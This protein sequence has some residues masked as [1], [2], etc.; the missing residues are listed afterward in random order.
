MYPQVDNDPEEK[1]EKETEEED[2]NSAMGNSLIFR[3]GWSS[4]FEESMD[5]SGISN[6]EENCD[7]EK[8]D[9]ISSILWL[10]NNHRFIPD[11]KANVSLYSGQNA[12]G[13]LRLHSEAII[14]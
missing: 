13:K 8:L 10:M 6:K 9:F 1:R 3:R 7:Q 14:H 2:S 11:F 4:S 5:D 12:T